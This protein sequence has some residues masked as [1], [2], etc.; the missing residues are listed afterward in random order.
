MNSKRWDASVVSRPSEVCTSCPFNYD[1]DTT[2]EVFP[3]EKIVTVFGKKEWRLFKVEWD[4]YAGKKTHSWVTEH[5]S[6]ADDCNESI[7]EFWDRNGKTQT[8]LTTR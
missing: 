8:R 3:V 2:D 7:N 4:D 5:S 1:T 6:L